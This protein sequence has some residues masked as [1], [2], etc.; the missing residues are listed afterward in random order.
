MCHHTSLYYSIN[1]LINWM[2]L[3]KFYKLIDL[4]E[5][6]HTLRFKQ[7]GYSQILLSYAECLL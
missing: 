5:I 7:S 3:V 4:E 1:A 2:K 6:I